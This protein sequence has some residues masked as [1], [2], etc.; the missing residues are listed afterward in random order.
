MRRYRFMFRKIGSC[1]G[2]DPPE[3]MEAGP[4]TQPQATQFMEDEIEK[5]IL[6][7]CEAWVCNYGPI[8]DEPEPTPPEKEEART[9]LNWPAILTIV[10]VTAL[11]HWLWKW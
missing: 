2:C 5:R 4:F 3:L 10:V 11:L 7:T 8:Y 1:D 9:Y 6:L